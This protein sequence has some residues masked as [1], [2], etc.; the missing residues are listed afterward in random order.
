MK[1]YNIIYAD[2]PWTYQDKNCQGA[3]ARHYK[4]MTDSELQSLPIKDIAADDCVLFM[5]ATYPKLK[6]ALDVID[7]WGFKYKTIAFQWIKQNKSGDGLFFGLG[8]WT[9]G[10]SEPCLLATK[11][12]PK[13][14]SPNVSQLVFSPLRNH[15]QKPD[16]VRDKIIELVGDLPRIELFARN[17]ADGWDSWGDEIDSDISFDLNDNNNKE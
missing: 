15:S 2:P 16:C 17:K 4:T 7:A 13:R 9:R 11:G 8:R 1:K 12:K 14:I 6:E 10:N 5:W 3:C